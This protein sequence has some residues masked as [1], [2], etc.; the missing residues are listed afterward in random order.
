MWHTIRMIGRDVTL[1]EFHYTYLR[2]ASF[3]GVLACLGVV[4]SDK[5]T[6]ADW[7]KPVILSRPNENIAFVTIFSNRVIFFSY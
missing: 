6:R 7:S 2:E 3:K 5:F 1:I 4:G